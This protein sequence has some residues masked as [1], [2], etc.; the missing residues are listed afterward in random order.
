MSMASM[1][2]LLG[3][4]LFAL[5]CNFFIKQCEGG[6]VS[7]DH[8]TLVINGQRR[9]LISGSIHY[10]R[11]TPEMWPDLIQ[12]SKDGGLDVI[13]TYVFW[14]NHEPVQGQY[15]FEERF[16]LVRFVKTVQQAGL[17]VHLR[18]GPYACA[19]WNY[20]GFPIWLHFIPGIELRTDNNPFKKE[21]QR[22]TTKIVD[23]MKEEQ[24]FASQGGPIILCQIENEYELVEDYYG[25][26]GHSYV[27][28]AAS[29]AVGLNTGVPWVMCRQGDAPDPII[30][31]CNGFYCDGFV[32]NSIYKPALWT[33]NYV[34]WFQSFGGRVP[35]RPVEDLA[36]SVARFF[37]TGGAL[38]NYYMYHGGTNFGRT[39][40]G[41]FVATSYDYDA[42]IDEYGIVRE[43]KW[44]HLKELH[45]AIK[46]CETALVNSDP[47]HL[48]LGPQL[49]AHMYYMESGTCAAFLANI[50]DTSDF[51][52]TF[53]GN[54]YSLPAWSVSI[55]PDC[56]NVIF[57]TAKIATQSTLVQSKL[58]NKVYETIGTNWK[59]YNEAI[60]IWGNNSLTN[61]GLLEQI[62]TTEDSSDYLWYTISVEIT[63][64]EPLPILHVE[65]LGHALHVFV[66]K[67][68][69]GTGSGYDEYSNITL[70]K[71]IILNPGKNTLDLLS[72]T[73]GL[74][75]FGG[76]YDAIGAGITGPITLKG[77]KNGTQDLS[78]QEW[79]YQIG[80]EGEQLG[81]YLR[82]DIKN[83]NWNSGP[84]P[85]KNQS[86]IWYKTEFEAPDGNNP[87]ALDLVSMGK[88]HAWVNGHSIGRYWPAF[89]SPENGCNTTCD[90]RGSYDQYKCV[91]NCGQP[92]QKLYH[93]P[94]S[95][96]QPTGNVLVL[97]EEIGGDPTKITFLTRSVESLCARVSE[98]F[99]SPI[100]SWEM[101][102]K[103]GLSSNKPELS[104]HCPEGQLISSIK[105]AS[106]GTPQGQ[107][108]NFEHGEC[109][110]I[111]TR[112]I[113]EEICIGRRSCSVPVSVK[114]LGDPC[115]GM[116]KTLAVQA[117]CN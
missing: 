48:D 1:K 35:Y 105:F 57:N 111:D 44:S 114:R 83:T 93:V 52:V 113:I 79:T 40:G 34:G 103:D 107:C 60:G 90:Y 99:P 32:P 98:S 56:N 24:L 94:R 108:G 25:E 58:I 22:F 71:S 21:M 11:S 26:P 65:S 55:L 97:L 4:V 42:P 95:W 66:N 5:L 117:I 14:D 106:F 86:M 84:N 8:R 59:W 92:S 27:K 6:N 3:V 43:P 80:L 15:Y 31:T 9:I 110:A 7:Y 67:K 37:E 70:E 36:F 46:L 73:V 17:F 75:N 20:G 100:D 74:E 2:K 81:L 19:E 112:S 18:I 89:L 116:D 62:F 10:P 61:T 49:E 82:N 29:M 102:M 13:E 41:P 53:N 104:L 47:V 45:K 115:P 96:I 68:F 72:I 76:F 51:N 30:N 109:N 64:N 101:I 39:A 87:V 38:Q 28:W 69:A 85:P 50:N 78:M 33:E 54:T 23:M 12:K 88:G 91:K 77:L 63:D 16:D